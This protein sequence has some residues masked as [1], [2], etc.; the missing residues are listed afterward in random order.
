MIVKSLRTFGLPSFEALVHVP[1]LPA[2]WVVT[3]NEIK[4]DLFVHERLKADTHKLLFLHNLYPAI[5]VKSY[6]KR[7]EKSE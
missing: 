6:L 1:R 3:K 5:I 4:M 2:E 7:W